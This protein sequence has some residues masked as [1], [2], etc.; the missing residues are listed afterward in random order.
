MLTLKTFC[1]IHE[2][3]SE[4]P[5]ELSQTTNKSIYSV[6]SDLMKSVKEAR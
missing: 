4:K 6:R 1:I 3:N 2:A 5:S